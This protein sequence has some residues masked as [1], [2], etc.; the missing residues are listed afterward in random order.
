MDINSL[1]SPQD[2]PAQTPPPP[3]AMPSPS[4]L[5]I[6]SPS[7]RAVRQP[8]PSRTPSGLSQQITSSPQQFHEPHPPN[9]TAHAQALYQHLVPAMASPGLAGY[10]NG[11]G[12]HSATSTP[13]L[14]DQRSPRDSRMTPPHPLGRQAS[15]MDTLADLASMQHVQ[16]QQAARQHQSVGQRP[17]IR[18]VPSSYAQLPSLNN[19][20]DFV[21]CTRRNRGS[22]KGF[23]GYVKPS[24]TPHSVFRKVE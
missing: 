12:A 1:L 7:K 6:Q 4:L 3:A 10:T 17:S 11:R 2:S 19:F 9:S 5:H 8:M 21:G 16:V 23:A 15:G 24:D 14:F 22:P 20:L 13:P 18:Y